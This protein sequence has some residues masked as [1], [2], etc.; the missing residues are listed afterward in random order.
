MEF[1]PPP[2]NVVF[3]CVSRGNQIL[4]KFS[5]GDHE[6][7]ALAERCQE[8]APTLHSWYSHT[9]NSRTFSFLMEDN[10]TY[11]AI[12]DVSTGNS[13]TRWFLEQLRDSFKASKNG[14]QDEL[15]PFIGRLIS[16]L[17]SMSWNQT[18]DGASTDGSTNSARMLLLRK[19][20]EKYDG[21]KSKERALETEDGGEEHS[22][23]G[24]RIEL[25]HEPVGSVV[26]LRKSLSSRSRGPQHARKLWWC[27]VKVVLAIDVIL[28][29]VLFGVWLGVCR[30]FQC[31]S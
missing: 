25:P 26:S 22:D 17:K 29:L 11:F 24:I 2:G 30:G 5:G 16:S 12:V 27:Q 3:C 18:S 19:A 10:Y 6:L 15:V 7:E 31:L 23:R 4:H 1:Q 8:K 28:C 14:F 20:S 9:V 21:E 13:D